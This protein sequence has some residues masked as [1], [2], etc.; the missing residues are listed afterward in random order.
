MNVLYGLYH[1]DE[2]EI[3]VNGE[4]V[5]MSSPRDAIARGIGMVHQHFML[6]PGDDR[7]REHR[8]CARAAPGGLLDSRPPRRASREIS[9][10]L[11]PR[12]RSRRA[13]SRHLPSAQQ[14]RVEILKA[15]YRDADILILDEPT[16]VLTPQEAEELLRICGT[17]TSAGHVDHLHHPQAERGAR[18]SPTASPCCAAASSSERFRAAGATEEELA[19]LMVG[20]EV[21][22]ASREDAQRTRASH[23]SSSKTCACA[24]TGHPEGARV[25]LDVHAGEIVGIAGVDGNGQTELIDAHHRA[26]AA[27][28]AGGILVD[29]IDVTTRE[30]PTHTSTRLR[31]RS[32][33]PAAA[34]SRSR[35]QPAE[36]MASTTTADAL[37]PLRLAFPERLLERPGD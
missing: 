30:R 11:R 34:R 23:S 27:G 37:L 4:P 24:T 16:A 17:C 29:G 33:G 21:A 28:R 8:A 7:G 26:P 6:D 31:T 14:Q 1:P 32:R 20:R 3:L 10:Q 2:G 36:N 25:S 12:Y 9:A 18:R 13:A 5:Q 22:A 15:L 19:E 35:L